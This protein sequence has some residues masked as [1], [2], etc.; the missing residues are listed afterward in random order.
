MNEDKAETLALNVLQFVLSDETLKGR[1]ISITGLA[2]SDLNEAIYNKEFLGG[3][4]DFIL[5]NEADLLTF[6]KEFGIDPENPAKA[7]RL[8]P[9]ST[10]NY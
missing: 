5:G 3:V 10:V 9:G 2:P 7:R 4:L 8:V 6:C 1:F